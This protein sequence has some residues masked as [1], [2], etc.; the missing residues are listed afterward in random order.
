RPTRT[1]QEEACVAEA[2][3][4]DSYIAGYFHD[5]CR[6]WFRERL[7]RPHLWLTPS[8]THALEMAALLLAL[9]PGDEVIMPSFTFVSSAN[10][11][12][13]HGATP[14]FVDIRPDTMNID[15]T[16]V[17][18]AITPRTR[19]I[20]V[21]HYAG[22]ACDMDAIA[23]IAARHGLPLI[24]DAAHAVLA[25]WKG[26]PLGTL[27]DMGVIS[28]HETKNLTSGEGGMLLLKSPHLADRAD[29]LQ[30]KGTNRTAFRQGKAGFYSWVDFG[31]SWSLG[32][33]ASALLYANLQQADAILARRLALWQRYYEAFAPLAAGGHVTLPTLPEGAEHNGTI[34]YLKLK[35]EAERTRFIQSLSAQG[36][37]CVFHYIPL[38]SSPAG[39]AL[40]R[41]HGADRYTTTE[42]ARLVRLPL[43]YGLTDEN[44][45][46]VIQ[47]VQAF[48]SA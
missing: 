19:A 10:A 41:F 45:A 44:A 17:E 8:C 6:T 38:H 13:M 29:I 37:D 34:F 32:E 40:G 3:R 42:S 16:L 26:Q 12:A 18:A 24:E 33:M 20:M 4:A 36:V 1:G 47:A 48:F 35:D 31:S 9:K 39:R 21:M 2:L 46:R 14:V 22:I 23:A 7:S 27:G 11:F 5:A 25:C 43:F 28:F 15:E 30:H